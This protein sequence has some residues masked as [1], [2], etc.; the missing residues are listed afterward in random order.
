V[1]QASQEGHPLH[2]EPF[3]Q[4]PRQDQRVPLP[5]LRDLI[6]NLRKSIELLRGKYYEELNC[7]GEIEELMNPLKTL[8]EEVVQKT[9]E[10]SHYKQENMR[11]LEESQKYKA[12]EKEQLPMFKEAI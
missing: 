5:L 3:G 10:A 12:M 6:D 4:K 11:L 2:G 8:Q 1:R 9:R 7:E